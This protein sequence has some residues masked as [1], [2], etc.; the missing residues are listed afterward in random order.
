[1]V[2]AETRETGST[3]ERVATLTLHLYDEVFHAAPQG[4]AC[5]SSRVKRYSDSG[6]DLAP[7][8]RQPKPTGI[9]LHSLVRNLM[10]VCN[11][12]PQRHCCRISRH[13]LLSARIFRQP[14][15]HRLSYLPKNILTRRIVTKHHTPSQLHLR[16][17][18]A[19]KFILARPD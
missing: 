18:S 10:G 19:F 5:M 6:F 15:G 1:M 7:S 8:L 11:P 3:A 13:S 4:V 16:R 12:L 2:R 17:K 14:C 9:V